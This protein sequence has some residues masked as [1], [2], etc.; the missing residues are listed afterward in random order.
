MLEQ[1]RE[2]TEEKIR[3]VRCPVH[4]SGASNVAMVEEAGGG[5]SLQAEMCCEELGAAIGAVLRE[6]GQ[7]QSGP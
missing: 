5:Y 3:A 2:Q 7:V 1:W 6:N 4:G